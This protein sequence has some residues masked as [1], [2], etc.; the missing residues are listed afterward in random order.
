[1]TDARRILCL[2]LAALLCLSALSLPAL[3]DASAEPAEVSAQ[4]CGEPVTE[5]PVPGEE[6][7]PAEDGYPKALPLP[8]LTGRQ[9]I[10]TARIAQSQI[11]YTAKRGTVYGSWWNSQSGRLFSDYTRT[12]WCGMFA[13]WCAYQ[14]GAGLN[15]AYDRDAALADSLFHWLIDN[16]A[17]DT[18]FTTEPRPG[19]F[20]FFGYS[21]G[22]AH[23]VVIVTDYDPADKTVT[24]VGGNQTN[25]DL[26]NGGDSANGSIVSQKAIEWSPDAR[27]AIGRRILGYGRPNYSDAP[28]VLARKAAFDAAVVLQTAVGL[29][30]GQATPPDAAALLQSIE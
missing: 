15:K 25:P 19:D 22:V 6:P 12:A 20:I 23:H 9:S 8:E 13:A 24:Y 1:M 17:S 27:D 18:G 16:A 11:G 10:D 29:A 14:A 3:A 7:P 2:L 21:D 28:H 4:A 5:E 30:D 26:E